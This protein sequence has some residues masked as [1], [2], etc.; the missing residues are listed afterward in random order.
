MKVN[1]FFL[2]T[3]MNACVIVQLNGS[4]MNFQSPE[5]KT[6]QLSRTQAEIKNLNT[7]KP[8]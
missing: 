8:E 2:A 1:P 7:L 3:F 4:V 5:K 6:S